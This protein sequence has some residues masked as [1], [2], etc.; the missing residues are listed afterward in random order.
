VIYPL[1]Y[2]SSSRK[3]HILSKLYI[4]FEGAADRDKRGGR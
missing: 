2:Y 3:I 4:I 1:T